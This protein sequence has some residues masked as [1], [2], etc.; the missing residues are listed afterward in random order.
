MEC[1][2]LQSK[3]NL[4]DD[5]IENLERSGYF[6]EQDIDLNIS[7]MKRLRDFYVKKAGF[8]IHDKYLLAVCHYCNGLRLCAR[9]K[10]MSKEMSK[11]FIRLRS[12]GFVFHS[13][14]GNEYD[15]VIKSLHCK[16]GC[17]NQHL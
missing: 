10:D 6:T 1:I 3:I 9:E 2:D 11:E 8:L 7:A 15:V 12:N 14:S 5:Q 13:I 16:P 4:L 17:E